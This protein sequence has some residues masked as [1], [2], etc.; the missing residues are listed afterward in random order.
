MEEKPHWCLSIV[1][2]TSNCF[3]LS[4]SP[5]VRFWTAL[6]CN[7]K[8]FKEEGDLWKLKAYVGGAFYLYDI[9]SFKVIYRSWLSIMCPH[10]I[11][12]SLVVNFS[13]FWYKI[14]SG[15]IVVQCKIYHIFFCCF[16]LLF[17]IFLLLGSDPFGIINI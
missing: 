16:T 3:L 11:L 12:V 1:Q 5:A 17:K 9:P 7:I 10:A 13:G 6:A 2:T 15:I 4:S 14:I 8:R